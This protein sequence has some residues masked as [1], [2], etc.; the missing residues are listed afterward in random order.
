MHTVFDPLRLSSVSLDVM[1]INRGAPQAILQR[2]Q[3]RLA[4]LIESTLRG[5]RLYQSLWPAGTSAQTPLEQLPVVTRTQLM[6]NFDI[7]ATDPKI[8]L[9]AL[10][11][12]TADPNRIAEPW[13]GRYV[14]WESSGTSGQPGI[15]VQDISTMTVYDALESVRRCATRPLARWFD[16]LG[17]TERIA[18]VGATGGH[19]ASYASVQRLRAIN[20]VLSSTMRSFSIQV[21]TNT[22]VAQLN[23]FSPT[24]IVTYPTVASLLA[25]EA[26]RNR[27]RARPREIWTGGESLSVTART[28]IQQTLGSA[29]RNSYGA[30]E[31][32]AMGW[33]CAQGQMHANADWVILEPVDE[34]F[35]P[36]PVGQ[37]SN[38]VLVT[39]LVNQVQPLVRYNINDQVAIHTERCSCGSPL[40][41]ITVQG[42]S[43]EQLVMA[44]ANGQTVTLLP[45]ALSTVLEDDAGVFDF[46]LHQMD[47]CTLVLHLPLDG[48]AG[49]IA[50][51]RACVVLEAFATAQGVESVQVHAKV[52][53]VVP[54]GRSG[55]ACRITA[56]R[57]D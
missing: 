4:Q 54:R 52:G 12:F 38:S 43:D 14:V 33:E 35:R 21:P 16:P 28:H 55:K 19:F 17:L 3:T 50:A 22:L 9:E 36:V 41:V 53:Y 2:Q 10:R 18:F 56:Y 26:Q 51:A 31:F 29:V 25:D 48:E 6:E 24:V 49:R 44:A 34:H 11:Q 23:D 40:P 8:T 13:L 46:Y 45:L 47:D 27:F 20:P 1:A 7:W 5:S 57:N 37:P 15:F 42:R 39:N 32:L 30:S